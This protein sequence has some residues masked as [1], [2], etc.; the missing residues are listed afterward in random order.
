MSDQAG[1]ASAFTEAQDSLNH[2]VD[3]ADGELLGVGADEPLDLGQY[4]AGEAG[5]PEAVKDEPADEAP[6]GFSRLLQP[7]HHPRAAVHEQAQE[8]PVPQAIYGESVNFKSFAENKSGSIEQ[9]AASLQLAA[10]Q[11]SIEMPEGLEPIEDH[12]EHPVSNLVRQM[13]EERRPAEEIIGAL[14]DRSNNI[15]GDEEYLVDP[16]DTVKFLDDHAPGHVEPELVSA[17]SEDDAEGL[18]NDLVRG[19]LLPRVSIPLAAAGN[20]EDVNLHIQ[21]GN[22]TLVQ[23]DEGFQVQLSMGHAVQ[24][25]REI[26]SELSEK[27]KRLLEIGQEVARIESEMANLREWGANLGNLYR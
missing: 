7:A 23:T 3:M 6:R 15:E 17:S 20:L 21:R 27:E 5:Q 2:E 25:Q 19:H 1:A 14:V 9:F 11:S 16:V 18:I 24:L 22:A 4:E 13:E 10:I 12:R 8:I 26:E